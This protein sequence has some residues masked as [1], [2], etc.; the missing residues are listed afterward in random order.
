MKVSGKW[1]STPLKEKF[2]MN[3][4]KKLQNTERH[5]LA[6]CGSLCGEKQFMF[7]F[8]PFYRFVQKSC[9]NKSK[10]S[11]GFASFKHGKKKTTL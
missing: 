11:T 1:Y 2:S 9:L 7:I 6:V 5:S 3:Y 8:I 4:R 10:F